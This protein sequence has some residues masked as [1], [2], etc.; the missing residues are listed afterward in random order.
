MIINVRGTSGSGKTW[1]A[2]KLL[3]QASES[4]ILGE[5]GKVVGHIIGHDH[6][7]MWVIGPYTDKSKGVDNL[8]KIYATQ[9]WLCNRVRHYAPKGHVFFEGLLCSHLHSRYRDLARELGSFMFLYLDT[10]LEVCLDRIMARRQ[11]SPRTA[12]K[13]FNPAN[14]T[15]DFENVKRTHDKMINDSLDVRMMSGKEALR[16]TLEVLNEVN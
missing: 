4:P 9:D 8:P 2:K 5:N 10:P 14:T 1:V 7:R 13:P 11:L 15:R 6:R 3:E 12:G 16:T